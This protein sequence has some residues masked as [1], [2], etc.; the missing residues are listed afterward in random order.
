MA[1]IP[2]TSILLSS[3]R[4]GIRARKPSNK[5]WIAITGNMDSILCSWIRATGCECRLSYH[6]KV[7]ANNLSDGLLACNFDIAGFCFQL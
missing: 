3:L 1:W 4:S 5:A 6:C 7:L 2:I